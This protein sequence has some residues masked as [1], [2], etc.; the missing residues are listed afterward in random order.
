MAGRKIVI[1]RRPVFI[2]LP[3]IFLL[4]RSCSVFLQMC[5][6]IRAEDIIPI[7]EAIIVHSARH[8]GT[9]LVVLNPDSLSDSS[10][11][12]AMRRKLPPAP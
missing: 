5:P 9:N 4:F 6:D 2:F 1:K 11:L 10:Q 7:F 8:S 3:D 12:L